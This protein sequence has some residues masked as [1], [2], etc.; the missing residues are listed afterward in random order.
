MVWKELAH[1]SY[2]FRQAAC[3]AFA[4]HGEQIG[5]HG[6]APVKK[7][8]VVAG[9][10]PEAI[11]MAPVFFALRESSVVQPIFLATGQHREILHQALGVFGITPDH[12]LAVM[13]DNQSLDALTGRVITAV[14]GF[15]RLGD[16]AAMLVQG[17]TTTV[18]ASALAAFYAGIPLGHVEAG[19]RTHDMAAPWPE[20]M[21]RRLTSPL[22]RWN[23]APTRTGFDNLVAEGI[24]AERCH[25]TGN[26]VIDALHLAL[27]LPNLSSDAERLNRLRIRDDFLL[28]SESGPHPLVLVTSHRRES[29]GQGLESV[30]RAILAVADA[31]PRVRV[32]YPVHSNPLVREPVLRLL[33]NHSS[34]ALIEPCDYT[35]FVWLMKSC[36]FVLS[37]SGGVQEEAPGLG[38][39]V[40]VLRSVTE[41][42]EGVTAGTCRLVGTDASTILREASVLLNDEVEYAKRSAIRNP[43]GDGK[44]AGRI[45]AVIDQHFAN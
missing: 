30:C 3:D 9:T 35:D 23:F 14:S 28:E 40:L 31:F 38:K 18:L 10:R 29:F 45:R 21:N 32:V 19:L 8:L 5:S 37:D 43:Y 26:T 2:S 13:Q 42:P 12:D 1:A 16:Y 41:R 20:E 4:D 25:I 15:L 22:A 36:R 27:A 7:V 6:C 17:D 39:P 33:G 11:K 44:A 24:P 34:I